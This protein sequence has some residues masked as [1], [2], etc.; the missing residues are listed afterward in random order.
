MSVTAVSCLEEHRSQLSSR[1]S[2][3]SF[4]PT[5]SSAVFPGPWRGEM[6]GSLRNEH[7]ENM[8]EH[9]HKGWKAINLILIGLHGPM[10]RCMC[11]WRTEEF[12]D[13]SDDRKPRRFHHSNSNAG[14]DG[15]WDDD[16][17]IKDSLWPR[18]SLL[19]LHTLD[20]WGCPHHV[21]QVG[22]PDLLF[23]MS[24]QGQHH[25]G[26]PCQSSD[27]TVTLVQGRLS[28]AFVE[29]SDLRQRLCVKWKRNMGKSIKGKEVN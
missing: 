8:R 11:L 6:R 2:G 12:L 25:S 10:N 26:R 22:F 13:R 21:T 23:Y 14:S 7:S 4:L 17:E 1:P 18:S 5:P 16:W 9:S 15:S 19:F 27:G 29:W 24:S 28:E 3:S 20:C